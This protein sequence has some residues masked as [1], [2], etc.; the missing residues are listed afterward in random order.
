MFTVHVAA[1]VL[2]TSRDVED[3]ELISPSKYVKVLNRVL[4]VL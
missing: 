3:V 2:D 4:L 1:L